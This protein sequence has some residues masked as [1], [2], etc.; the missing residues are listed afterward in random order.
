MERKA[1]C[2]DESAFLEP[3]HRLCWADQN[4]GTILREF[5]DIYPRL[6]D[7]QINGNIYGQPSQ[8]FLI[9]LIYNPKLSRC[10][11]QFYYFSIRE[12][13]ANRVQKFLATHRSNWGA[14]PIKAGNGTAM[15]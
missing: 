11:C 8:N 7:A 1:G 6:V 4:P 15:G 5:K 10:G 2:G 12:N 14:W 3:Q 13:A 9:L